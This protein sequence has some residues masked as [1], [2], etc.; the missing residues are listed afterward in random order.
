MLAWMSTYG[1]LWAERPFMSKKSC[2]SSG[3]HRRCVL[4]MARLNCYI[5]HMRRNVEASTDLFRSIP[6]SK[7]YYPMVYTS[8]FWTVIRFLDLHYSVV[9]TY[10]FFL[11]A[12]SN[13]LYFGTCNS[14]FK[15][16]LQFLVLD[17]ELHILYKLFNC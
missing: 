6:A 17:Y 7:L 8:L 3:N 5:W 16:W 13:S 11:R 2:V 14:F 9:I 1:R 10:A 4:R 15:A 12:L